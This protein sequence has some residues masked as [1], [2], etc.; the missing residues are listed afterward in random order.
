MD[1]D[2]KKVVEVLSPEYF[3]DDHLTTHEMRVFEYL[4]RYVSTLNVE[5]SKVF[6]NYITG[7]EVLPSEISIKVLFNGKVELE[8]MVPQSNTCSSSLHLSRCFM[9]YS[10]MKEILDNILSNRNLWQRLDLVYL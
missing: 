9:S 10:P 2:D 6:L 5:L 8:N 4:Q 7:M 1:P 3:P